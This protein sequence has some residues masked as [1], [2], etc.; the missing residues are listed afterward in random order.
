[1]RNKTIAYLFPLLFAFN[2]SSVGA[3][4]I[5]SPWDDHPVVATDVA[6]TC[7]HPDPVPTDLTTEGFYRLDDPTH[8]IV[9]P[10]RMAAYTRSSGPAKAAAAAIVNEADQYRITGSRAAAVCTVELLDQMGRNNALG[11]HMSSSQA[12]YV[13]GW[14]AGAMALAFLKVRDSGVATAEQTNVIGAWL[15]RLG[16]STRNWYDEAL[17]KK[18]DGNNHLYWAG[19]QLVATAAVTGNRKDLD[20]AIAAYRNGIGQITA[21]GTLPLEM[22]RGERALH[23]H[24]YA[25]APLVMIAE[26]GEDNGIPLYVENGHA[27]RRLEMTSVAGLGDPQLFAHR[28]GIA[29]EHSQAPGGDALAWAPPYLRRYPEASL[30]GYVDRAPTLFSFYLGGLPAPG[31]TS[32]SH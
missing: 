28:A 2:G 3:Q 19:V 20:W 1:M 17:R 12:Y 16:T 25:L 22:S 10:K 31:R 7:P 29:Q 13:Q 24:L 26:F 4:T 32:V 15:E 6:S 21:D 14:L 5:R 9:D 23:Y 27:L 11:G 18:P 8:S 30:Q